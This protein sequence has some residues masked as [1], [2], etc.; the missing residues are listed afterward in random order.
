VNGAEHSEFIVGV[1]GT[2]EVMALEKGGQFRGG[3]YLVYRT[4]LGI[5]DKPPSYK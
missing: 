2:V 4:E 3:L 5:F 1:L